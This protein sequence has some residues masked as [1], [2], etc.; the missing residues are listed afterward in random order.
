MIVP[1]H[2][3]GLPPWLDSI[4]ATQSGG[5]LFK[6]ALTYDSSGQILTQRYQHGVSSESIHKY[7]Y[8]NIDRL[9]RWWIDGGFGG[10]LQG[11]VDNARNA[12]LHDVRSKVQQVTEL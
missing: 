7:Y 9:T 2:F 6:Q 11:A 4:T 3:T 5:S 1:A 10:S 8:D 12:V